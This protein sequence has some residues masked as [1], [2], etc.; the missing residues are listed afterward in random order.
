MNIFQDSLRLRKDSST[1]NLI[2]DVL[3]QL[4]RPAAFFVAALEDAEHDCIR[5]AW[6]IHGQNHWEG[7]FAFVEIFAESFVLLVL[8]RSQL[9]AQNYL[10]TFRVEEGKW[11]H[12]SAL[13]R[14]W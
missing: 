2:Q 13:T 12:T 6:G 7:E 3:L 4:W 8:E 9:L 1:G 5:E 10:I 14:F 11:E